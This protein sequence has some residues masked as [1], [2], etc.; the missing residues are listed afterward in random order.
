MLL[1]P[2]GSTRTYTL[3]PHTT[4]FRSTPIL[5]PG[6]IRGPTRTWPASCGSRGTGFSFHH[7]SHG[8]QRHQ[9]HFAWRT[10]IAGSRGTDTRVFTGDLGE[11][12]AVRSASG[13]QLGGALSYV[14]VP[15]ASH[16]ASCDFTMCGRYGRSEERRVG[17]ECVSTC[18]SRWSPDH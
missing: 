7:I 8:V 5:F 2:P 17:K 12:P 15:M 16:A 9:A 13:P 11:M 1:R 18:R 14:H 4:L 3:C 6:A 10:A